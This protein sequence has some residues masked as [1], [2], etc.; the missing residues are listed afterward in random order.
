MHLEG[1]EENQSYSRM[2]Q[3]SSDIYLNR[4]VDSR[5][6]YDDLTSE[7]ERSKVRSTCR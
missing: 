5:D 7:E 3:A 2:R 4:K 1:N 6:N